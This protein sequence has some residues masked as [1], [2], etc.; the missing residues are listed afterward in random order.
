M[1]LDPCK[2]CPFVGKNKGEMS[3]HTH[4]T[5]PGMDCSN[6]HCWTCGISFKK[7]TTMKRHNTTVRA[8]VGSKEVQGITGRHDFTFMG[9][10]PTK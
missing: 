7:E 5:H 1:D 3:L 6:Y 9:Y 2:Y 8:L 4:R 10:Y